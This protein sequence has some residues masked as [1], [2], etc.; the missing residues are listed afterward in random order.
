MFSVYLENALKE[1]RTILP[2]ATNEL[3]KTLPSEIAYADDV[4]FVGL[5]FV[6]TEEVQNTLH[7]YNLLVNIDKTE[8][9]TLSRAGTEYKNTKKSWNSHRRRRRRREE[10]TTI[11]CKH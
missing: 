9:T 2:R 8:F 1:V 4:D 11:Q 7:K 6:D 10:E 5:S 3:E